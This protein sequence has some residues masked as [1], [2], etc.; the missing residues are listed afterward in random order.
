MSCFT[1]GLGLNTLTMLEIREYIT[2]E[3]IKQ[4]YSVKMLC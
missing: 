2:L 4:C 3:L 1:K